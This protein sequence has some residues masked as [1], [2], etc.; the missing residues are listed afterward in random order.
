MIL[1]YL[2]PLKHPDA[3]PD[4]YGKDVPL[5]EF[6]NWCFVSD[7]TRTVERLGRGG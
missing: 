2:H 7:V 1:S 4:H 6:R 3:T 5:D